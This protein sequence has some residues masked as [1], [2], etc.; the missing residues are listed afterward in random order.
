MPASVTSVRTEPKFA[1]SFA[2]GAGPA[3]PGGYSDQD[4]AIWSTAASPR[5]ISGTVA[6][7]WL[8]RPLRYALVG[9][10]G[11]LSGPHLG[12]IRAALRALMD[13]ATPPGETARELTP[14]L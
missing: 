12:R 4:Q 2:F 14:R 13:P 6:T 8:G 5:V 3:G 9:S 7:S 10:P 11:N 1:K